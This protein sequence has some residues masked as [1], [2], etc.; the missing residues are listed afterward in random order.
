MSSI[1]SLAISARKLHLDPSIMTTSRF[2]ASYSAGLIPSA[3]H[4][5][6]FDAHRMIDIT[7]LRKTKLNEY[8]GALVYDFVPIT[9]PSVTEAVAGRLLRSL[10]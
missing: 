9:P 8:L 7:L 5:T 10:G 2:S 1:S 6:I 3:A 4:C